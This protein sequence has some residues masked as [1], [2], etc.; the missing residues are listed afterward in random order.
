[1]QRVV[2]ELSL[3]LADGVFQGGSQQSWY[4]ERAVNTSVSGGD[5]FDDVPL[6]K[7]PFAREQVEPEP[8]EEGTEIGVRLSRGNEPAAGRPSVSGTP[9]VGETLTAGTAGITDADGKTRADDG[10]SGFAW[11]YQWYTVDADG[12]SNRTPIPGETAQTYSLTPADEDLRIIVEASFTDDAGGSEGPLAS[13]PFPR[14]GTVAGSGDPAPD[15]ETAPGTSGDIAVSVWYVYF[16][17]V[18]YTAVEGGA[19]ARVTVRLNA[20][21][22][23]DE[24]LTVYLSLV[25]HNGGAVASDYSGIPESVT[26]QPGRTEAS[27]TVRATDDNADDDG[28]HIRFGINTRGYGGD[29]VVRFGVDA[30][31]AHPEDLEDLKIG[32]G[33]HTVTVRLRD[34]NGPKPV[35]G[36]LRRTGLYRYR[37]RSRRHRDGAAERTAGSP[38]DRSPDGNA[39]RRRNRRLLRHTRQRDLRIERDR[40]DL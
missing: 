18:E 6:L 34:N 5:T 14:S 23:H 7:A 17:Q 20:P 3:P 31:S 22:K 38:G 37:G 2:G 15:P 19:G 30:L 9:Q 12:T 32:Q 26:F 39:H 29:G 35:T 25:E 40:K 8:T 21:W 24:A 1:M 33:P 11:T 28:E 16:D 36:V 4:F 10:D 27:F 13:D